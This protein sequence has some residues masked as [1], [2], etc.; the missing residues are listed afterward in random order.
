MFEVKALGE[1][2]IE[3]ARL[4]GLLHSI[5]PELP[6]EPFDANSILNDLDNNNSDHDNYSDVC[7]DNNDEGINT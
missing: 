1:S 2:F 4:D 6:A 3:M 5:V 7:V